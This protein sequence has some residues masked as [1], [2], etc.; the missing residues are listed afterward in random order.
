[1]VEPP[2]KEREQAGLLE[3]AGQTATVGEFWGARAILLE[4]LLCLG[5][6]DWN[7][8]CGC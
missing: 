7:D 8:V 2:L 5:V 4:R 3:K 6:E 1:M